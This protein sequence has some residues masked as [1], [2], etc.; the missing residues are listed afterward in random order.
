MTEEKPKPTS[1]PAPK[2]VE[3]PEEKQKISL[4]VALV[5]S[6]VGAA[7]FLFGSF[8]AFYDGIPGDE[9]PKLFNAMSGKVAIVLI[10]V[11][12]LLVAIKRFGSLAAIAVSLALGAVLQP[13]IDVPSGDNLTIKLANSLAGDE[14]ASAGIGM[15]AALFGALICLL[16][17]FM[18]PKK[19]DDKDSKKK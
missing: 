11:S 18:I 19:K 2:P 16:A 12:V 9:T 14:V 5:V 1:E 8:L 7:L 4:P 15:Y 3:P 17:V 6:L 10:L 13:V